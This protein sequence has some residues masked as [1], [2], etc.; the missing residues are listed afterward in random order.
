MRISLVAA[1]VGRVNELERFCESL[2]LQS[3]RDFE[4][5]VVDQNSDD[6]L[7]PLIAR[8]GERFS[9]HHLRAERGLSH[10]R[11]VALPLCCGDLVAFPDDDCVYPPDLL[12]RV[13][14]LFA[15][16]V[17]LDGVSGRCLT[18]EGTPRGRWAPRSTVIGKYNI[19]GRCISFT[20]FL[21]RSLV[22][23]IGPFDESLGLGAASPWLGAEDYDYLLRAAQAGAVLYDPSV[24]VLHPDL[25]KIFDERD[26]AKRYGNALGFGRFLAKH[27]YPLAF[28]AYYSARYLAGVVWNLAKGHTAKAQYRWAALV[29]NFEGWF[30]T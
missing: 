7:V 2:A 18:T 25:T 3:Y 23:R 8:F 28:V 4:L 10:A 17:D 29:G 12:E 16:R 1:T 5:L 14:G 20:M 11:N 19:F 30:A 13:A 24:E 26:L 27:H 6:R 21:R 9:V 15:S 22:E